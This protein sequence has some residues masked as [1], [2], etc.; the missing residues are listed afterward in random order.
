M[1]PTMMRNVADDDEGRVMTMRGAAYYSSR[2]WLGRESVLP[3][4][5]LR[6]EVK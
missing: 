5:A 3:L 4:P 1:M 6:G 2:A